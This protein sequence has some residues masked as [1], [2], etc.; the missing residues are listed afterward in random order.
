M[1]K[2]NLIQIINNNAFEAVI[3]HFE[4]QP[5]DIRD[6]A[7]DKYIELA[8]K[9]LQEPE[10]YSDEEKFDIAES[11]INITTNELIVEDMELERL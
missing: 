8:N 3:D 7:E 2:T 1:Y 9:I 10:E 5:I 6:I 11:F 4:I